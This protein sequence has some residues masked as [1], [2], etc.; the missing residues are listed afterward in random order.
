[1]RTPTSFVLDAGANASSTRI[2]RPKSLV[3]ARLDSLQSASGLLLAL[4]MWGHMFFVSSILISE[5]VM[6]TITKMF[7]RPTSA[8]SDARDHALPTIAPKPRSIKL[9]ERSST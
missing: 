7:D 5:Q 9:E 2:A 8:R 6:W 4:F 1:M 3:P